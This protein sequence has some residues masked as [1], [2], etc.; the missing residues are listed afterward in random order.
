MEQARTQLEG[1]LRSELTKLAD[2]LANRAKRFDG[3]LKNSHLKL[4]QS[5]AARE[6]F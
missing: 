5:E 4:W 1:A 6:I 2:I 3:K